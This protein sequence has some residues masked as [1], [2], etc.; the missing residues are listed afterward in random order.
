MPDRIGDRQFCGLVPLER[1]RKLEAA[2]N[3][4]AK[5]AARLVEMQVATSSKRIS[6]T[7]PRS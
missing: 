2:K 3:S 1:Y 5:A 4:E 6:E 7:E